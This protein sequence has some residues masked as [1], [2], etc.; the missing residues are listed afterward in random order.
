MIIILDPIVNIFSLDIV[1]V[2]QHL[3]PDSDLPVSHKTSRGRRKV[4]LVAGGRD[5]RCLEIR[6][7]TIGG[8]GVMNLTGLKS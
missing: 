6:C 5:T 1:V 8:S 7:L 3:E 2:L 4:N